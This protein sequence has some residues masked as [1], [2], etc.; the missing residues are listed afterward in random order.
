MGVSE[1]PEYRDYWSEDLI[2]HDRFVSGVMSRHR[3]EK[4]SQYFHCSLPGEEDA[5]DKLAKVRPLLTLCEESFHRCC[6]P[7]R[8]LSI[9]EAMIRFDGR[10]AWKQY[11]PKKPVKWGIKLW[12]LC[13]AFTGYCLA[14]TV[15]TG[16][17]DGP[18]DLGLGYRVVMTLMRRHLLSQHHLYTDNYFT[19]V[20]LAELR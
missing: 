1:R 6:A 17:A 18:A 12:C 8:D 15:Y 16:A 20:H 4:L 11:M 3:Y 7:S 13:D 19:S 2:L 14:F 5:R 10:L 9:D